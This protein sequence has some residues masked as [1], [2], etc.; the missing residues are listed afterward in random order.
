MYDISF[1]NVIN[2][3]D[4][5]KLWNSGENLSLL[6]S[7]TYLAI[8]KRNIPGNLDF[9]TLYMNNLNLSN[10]TFELF[11]EQPSVTNFDV[12]IHDNYTDV[13]ELIVP[14]SIQHFNFTVDPNIPASI[15]N[16]RFKI[17]YTSNSLSNNDLQSEDL[18]TIYPN[19][20]QSNYINLSVNGG[21]ERLTKVELFGL[22]GRKIQ[23][24][25]VDN[26]A[27]GHNL[28]LK[29]DNTL[30]NGTY[31][32]YIVADNRTEIEKILINR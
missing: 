26:Y 15:D 14:N 31:I 17:Q 27:L 22:D 25:D 13:S 23:T 18:F 6:S 19:P 2:Y 12:F 8:E 1:D 10:Y 32:L 9:N 16:T 28:K 29:I 20:V 21:L 24:I 4:A 7:N 3:N 11:L 30:Q 5:T